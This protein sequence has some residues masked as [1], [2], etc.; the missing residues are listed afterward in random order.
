MGVHQLKE[1]AIQ[2]EGIVSSPI[3]SSANLQV[4]KF[5]QTSKEVIQELEDELKR[6]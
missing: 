1:A 6:L 5:I 4:R 2:I 3:T